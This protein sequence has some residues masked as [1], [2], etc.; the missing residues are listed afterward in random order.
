M[1]LDTLTGLQKS[2]TYLT[3]SRNFVILAFYMA[4]YIF[5]L[6][7]SSTNDSFSISLKKSIV[8]N[9]VVFSFNFAKVSYNIILVV[10]REHKIKN[11]VWLFNEHFTPSEVVNYQWPI[12]MESNVLNMFNYSKLHLDL[13]SCEFPFYYSSFEIKYDEL[14]IDKN[15][16]ELRSFSLFQKGKGNNKVAYA[17]NGG[18]RSNNRVQVSRSLAIVDNESVQTV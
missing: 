12:C 16:K 11:S 6:R 10:S 4:Y 15:R 18:R 8:S 2:A 17:I 1:Y 3:V 7:Y 13:E 9:D 5:R 14:R